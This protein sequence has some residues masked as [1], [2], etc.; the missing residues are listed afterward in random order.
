[1]LD[2]MRHGATGR[3][4]YRGRLDDPLS[5]L[6]WTQ[7]CAATADGIWDEVVSSTLQRCSA[8][9][10]HFA[11]ARSLPLRLDER[12]VEYDFG[13]WQG[14]RIEDIERE[15]PAAIARYRADPENHPPPGGEDFAAFGN[16][17]G[18][19][20]D[21]ARGDGKRRVLVLTHG[22]VIRWVQCRLAGLPFGAMAE[23]AIANASV[24]RVAWR[25]L[26]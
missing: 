23:T 13:R 22:A 9:A 12:L 20:L 21:A 6:G 25:R 7:S 17:V 8:F 15:E 16:R 5:E 24:H 14:R 10:E 4:S 18:A 3:P 19:A 11:A 26:G 1:M 2:L